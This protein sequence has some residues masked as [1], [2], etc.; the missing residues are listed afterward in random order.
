MKIQAMG[1]T[2]HA[3]RLRCFPLSHPD[4]IGCTNKIWP[5]ASCLN[6]AERVLLKGIVP[7]QPGFGLI[8][9]T[10]CPH[11]DTAQI[12][13]GADQPRHIE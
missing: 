13:E 11:F 5:T 9:I 3:S 8:D 2:Q 1:I 7:G 6:E 10:V 12:G 4:F